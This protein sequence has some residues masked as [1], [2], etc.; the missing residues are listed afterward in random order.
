MTCGW[1]WNSDDPAQMFLDVIPPPPAI[2]PPKT[3]PE[4]AGPLSSPPPYMPSPSPAPVPAANLSKV[5]PLLEY[6]DE[7][8]LA[9]AAAAAAQAQ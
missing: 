7:V 1:T 5:D 9:N 6:D 3:P 4:P 8:E 2:P